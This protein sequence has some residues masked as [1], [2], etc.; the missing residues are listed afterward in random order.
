MPTEVA[1]D[2][3]AR[4]LAEALYAAETQRPDVLTHLDEATLL[5][6]R[7]D[8]SSLATLFPHALLCLAE[9]LVSHPRPSARLDAIRLLLLVRDRDRRR[10]EAAL[11]V[12]AADGSRG[13]QR[14]AEG[15]LSR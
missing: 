8:A 3:T 6:L 7:G 2:A 9:Q 11:R 14:A 10:V 4:R 15:A 12:L 5:R 13:V 1:P